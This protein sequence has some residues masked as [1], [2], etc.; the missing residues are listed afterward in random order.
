L[1]RRHENDATRIAD[2]VIGATVT[3]R[4]ALAARASVLSG[5]T[6]GVHHDLYVFRRTGGA[7]LVPRQTL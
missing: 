5:R 4:R 2:Q 6:V 3:V 7:R 1:Q